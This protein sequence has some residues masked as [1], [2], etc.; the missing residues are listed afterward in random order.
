MTAPGNEVIVLLLTLGVFLSSAYA[1]GRIHQWKKCGRER[2]EAY[3]N[4]YEKASRAIIGVLADRRPDPVA[5]PRTRQVA[6]Q[7]KPH[8][9]EEID[10]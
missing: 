2:D 3:R 8:H 1:I 9:R 10:A 5:K 4:G 6:S 7:R